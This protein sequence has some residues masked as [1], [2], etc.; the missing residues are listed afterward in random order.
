VEH[1]PAP[2]RTP[3]PRVAL[4]M[5]EAAAALGVSRRHLYT[6]ILPELRVIYSGRCRLVAVRELE[7]WA[8]VNSVRAA[9]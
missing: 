1:T 6:H 8:E 2:A 4:N 5:S 7:R 3:E 9:A